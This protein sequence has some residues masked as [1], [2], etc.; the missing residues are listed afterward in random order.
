MYQVSVC[1]GPP[2]VAAW[3]TGRLPEPPNNPQVGMQNM[4]T[5][6]PSLLKARPTEAG[7]GGVDFIRVEVPMQRRETRI[8]KDVPAGDIA[9]EIVAWMKG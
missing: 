4:R 6:M 1:A 3:S 5:V 2:L 8:V 9:R 7:A